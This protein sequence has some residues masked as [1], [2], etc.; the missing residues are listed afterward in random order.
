MKIEDL[1]AEILSE[2]MDIANIQLKIQALE[3]LISEKLKA[4]Q[5]RHELIEKLETLNKVNNN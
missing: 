1:K 2:E 4:N 3:M 5:M